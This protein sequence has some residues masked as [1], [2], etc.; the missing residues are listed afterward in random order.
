[1]SALDSAGR[2]KDQIVGI[3][4]EG[5]GFQPGG[6]TQASGSAHLNGGHFL[7]GQ[8]QAGVPG[9]LFT[10]IVPDPVTEPAEGTAGREQPL[11]FDELHRPEPQAEVEL[12]RPNSGPDDHAAAQ[13]SGVR[14]ITK[15][16][17]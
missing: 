5:F 15:L 16:A 6:P 11:V 7:F 14:R 12:A 13:A 4:V 3:V 1:M 9:I 17:D 10:S 8:D 2:S